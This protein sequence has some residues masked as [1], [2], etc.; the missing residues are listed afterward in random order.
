M[1]ALILQHLPLQDRLAAARVCQTWAEAAALATSTIKLTALPAPKLQRLQSWLQQHGQQL[2][3][4]ELD[5]EGAADNAVLQLPELHQLCSLMLTGCKLQLPSAARRSARSAAHAPAALLLPRL[6]SLH[7]GGFTVSTLSTLLQLTQVTSL[8][9]L[10]LGAPYTSKAEISLTPKLQ[11]QPKPISQA[12]STVLQHNTQLTQL[13][14]W[15]LIFEDSTLAAVSSLQRLQDC[16]VGIKDFDALLSCFEPASTGL[17]G[18]LLRG[19]PASLTSL[20]VRDCRFSDATR[21]TLPRQP[22]QLT[23]LKQLK[24]QNARIY[25]SALTAMLQLQELRLICCSFQAGG[26]GA[27]VNESSQAVAAFLAALEQMQQLE[28]LEVKRLGLTCPDL[29][30]QSYSA[31]TASTRLR[32]LDLCVE[33]A[34]PVPLGGCAGTLVVGMR[35]GVGMF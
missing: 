20:H 19:L 3:C 32:H 7:L 15:G 24:L 8:R 28:V 35:H 21:I 34:A 33:N 16:C 26:A 22:P 23:A 1:T 31:L 6:T 30:A 14:V 10:K 18:D 5:T 27:G 25:P 11:Q 29:P 13:N 17:S 4:L 12:L 9:S 2:T